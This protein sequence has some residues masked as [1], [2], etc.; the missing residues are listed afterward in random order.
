MFVIKCIPKFKDKLLRNT[1]GSPTFGANGYESPCG[2]MATTMRSIENSREQR[3][4][5]QF[6]S[7]FQG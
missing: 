3:K 5:N 6:H 7:K 1:S 2:L 4:I